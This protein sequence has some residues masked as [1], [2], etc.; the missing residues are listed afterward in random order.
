MIFSPISPVVWGGIRFCSR[1][2]YPIPVGLLLRVAKISVMFCCLLFIGFVLFCASVGV[3][4][5]SFCF[6]PMLC[7]A[8]CVALVLMLLVGVVLVF[9]GLSSV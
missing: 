1:V 8:C 5:H 9:C 4:V 2:G 3:D 7:C 6:P